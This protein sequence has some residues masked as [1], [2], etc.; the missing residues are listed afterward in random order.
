[1]C[2]Q[3]S[4]DSPW[5]LARRV[6]RLLHSWWHGDRIRIPPAEGRML[7][8][9]PPCF[10]VVSGQP[11]EIIGR[12]VRQ[13]AG[14]TSVVYSCQTRTGLGKLLVEPGSALPALTIEWHENGKVLRLMEA[15]VEVF[16]ERIK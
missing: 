12:H 6:G 9:R 5:A 16:S 3:M 8:L 13:G 4:D 15:D 1:V 2:S 14:K 7:R 10:L 11:L